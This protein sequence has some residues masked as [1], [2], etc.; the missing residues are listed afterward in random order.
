MTRQV[1]LAQQAKAGPVKD[2]RTYTILERAPLLMAEH[3]GIWDAL[4]AVGQRRLVVDDKHSEEAFPAKIIESAALSSPNVD[5]VLFQARKAALTAE[6]SCNGASMLSKEYNRSYDQ[7]Q[8]W[9][10]LRA[11]LAQATQGKKSAKRVL[12]LIA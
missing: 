11:V 9:L 8:E 5:E 2:S 4:D 7:Q 3:R 12:L 10:R 6:A 1:C